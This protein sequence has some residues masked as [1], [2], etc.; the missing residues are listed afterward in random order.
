[1]L[2]RVHALERG[3]QGPQRIPAVNLVGAVRPDQEHARRAKRAHEE[4]DQ[5][6]GRLVG[7]VQVLED[8]HER[9]LGRQ[10]ADHA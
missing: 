5:V 7:P 4:R 3:Q 10:P 2:N 9:L 6:E 8:E 1:V